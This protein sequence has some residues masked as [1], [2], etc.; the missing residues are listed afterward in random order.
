MPYHHA[1]GFYAGRVLANFNMWELLCL[2]VLEF[3]D[4]LPNNF[5]HTVFI[6]IRM[7]R[8]DG[9]GIYIPGEGE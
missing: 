4:Q 2:G 5:D 6:N 1:R 7:R 9:T 3:F 8:N